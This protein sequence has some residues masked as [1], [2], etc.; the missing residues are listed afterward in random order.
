MCYSQG[1]KEFLGNKRN[2]IEIEI[3]IKTKQSYYQHNLK[4]K[5]I[6]DLFGKVILLN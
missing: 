1:K 3:T 2:F 6:L 5:Y 4:H